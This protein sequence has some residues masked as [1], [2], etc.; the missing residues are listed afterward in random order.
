MSSTLELNPMVCDMDDPGLVATGTHG[1]DAHL[2]VAQAGSHLEELWLN[3]LSRSRQG[4][5][6]LLADPAP[7]SGLY[8]LLSSRPQQIEQFSQ[9]DRNLAPLRGGRNWN[10][11]KAGDRHLQ[12]EKKNETEFEGSVAWGVWHGA[13]RG[14]WRRAW[15]DVCGLGWGVAWGVV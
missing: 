14:A 12:R 15:R 4:G 2:G 13:W 8:Q 3:L 1:A 9:R 11:A 7:N 5:T 6:V 10:V